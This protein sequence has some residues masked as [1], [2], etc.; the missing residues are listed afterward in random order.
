MKDRRLNVLLA[1][2]VAAACSS[3]DSTGPTPPPPPPP[4]ILATGDWVGDYVILGSGDSFRITAIINDNGGSLS[5][6]CRFEVLGN[7]VFAF[8]DGFSGT[9]SGDHQQGSVSMTFDF[10]QLA[11]GVFTYTGNLQPGVMTGSLVA[12][13][14]GNTFTGYTFRPRVGSANRVPDDVGTATTHAELAGILRQALGE[15]GAQ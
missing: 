13:G 10:N 7:P 4:P 9:R 12:S 11:G 8:C 3:G 5:G 15:G 2:L 1:A 14:S 6:S